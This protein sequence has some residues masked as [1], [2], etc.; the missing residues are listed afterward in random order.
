M[1]DLPASSATIQAL[2]LSKGFNMR[3]E[4]RN[5]LA[6]RLAAIAQQ[7]RRASDDQWDNFVVIWDDHPGERVGLPSKIVNNYRESQT[8]FLQVDP[9]WRE[10]FADHTLLA[11]LDGLLATLSADPSPD[12][13]LHL[14]DDLVRQLDAPGYA[15]DVL[16]ALWGIEMDEQP[17]T[18]GPITLALMTPVRFQE[19]AQRMQR[20][21]EHHAAELT[22]RGMPAPEES[23]LQLM[24]PGY[25]QVVGEFRGHVCAWTKAVVSDP[26]KAKEIADTQIDRVLDVLHF[27]AA[28]VTPSGTAIGFGRLSEMA[29]G[30]RKTPVIATDD[31]RCMIVLA[32]IRPSQ[33]LVLDPPR[34]QRMAEAGM[35]AVGSILAKP[36]TAWSEFERTLLRALHWFG[37]AQMQTE[38]KNAVLSLAICLETAFTSSDKSQPV[39]NDIADGVAFVMGKT[40]EER[41]ALIARVKGFYGIRSAITHG[42]GAKVTEVTWV[43]VDTS[44][45]FVATVL[46]AL[47][48]RLGQFESKEQLLDW[49]KDQR[50]S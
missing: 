38:P 42:H 13:A 31:S 36:E 27:A 14:L 15:V 11:H 20:V 41:K 28:A 48:G 21:F 19:L 5:A 34:V 39:M 40:L 4:A 8:I 16:G 17:L 9:A 45:H 49:I 32:P 22:A 23:M 33:P 10:K 2:E 3:V 44:S 43:E 25:T 6:K 46:A 35:M 24:G 18:I 7:A 47:I 26:D 50:L 37:N 12:R 1:R 30:P 29:S